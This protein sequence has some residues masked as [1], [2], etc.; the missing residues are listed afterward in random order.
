M[1]NSSI[2]SSIACDINFSEKDLE[3]S[4]RSF[5]YMMAVKMLMSAI[6]KILPLDDYIAEM[7]MFRTRLGSITANITR[8]GTE[9]INT[10]IPGKRKCEELTPHMLNPIGTITLSMRYTMP[11][12]YF[13][14]FKTRAP[15]TCPALT[16]TARDSPCRVL[17][18]LESVML[19]SS[20]A[21]IIW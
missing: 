15:P 8:I 1:Q 16:S 17:T 12:S 18:E 3:T 4:E 21:S 20:L 10:S 11:L 6:L 9:S 5:R 13:S 19:T 2:N 14:D 7:R